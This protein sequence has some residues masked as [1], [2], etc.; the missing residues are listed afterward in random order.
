MRPSELLAILI[1]AGAVCSCRSTT[2]P[3]T[4]DGSNSTSIAGSGSGSGSGAD[5]GASS[6][7]WFSR[8]VTLADGTPAAHAIVVLT[9]LKTQGELAVTRTDDQG[10]FKVD[11]PGGDV[12][13]TAT[14]PGQMAYIESVDVSTDGPPIALGTDCVDAQGRIEIVDRAEEPITIR[15]DRLGRDVG[16]TFGASLEADGQF[17]V[18]LPPAAY[19]AGFPPEFAYRQ[20]V[21]AVPSSVKPSFRTAKTTSVE[22]VLD[23]LQGIE[24]ESVRSFAAGLP[25]TVRVLGIGESNHGTREFSDERT[26]LA[27]ELARKRDFNLVM[28][29]AGYGETLQLDRYIGGAKL[30]IADAVQ[31]LGYWTWDTKTFLDSLEQLRRYNA[32]TP[33]ARRIRIVGFDVQDTEGAI[34]YLTQR[35]GTSLSA[36]EIDRLG[37]LAVED[38]KNWKELDPVDRTAIRATL[39][40]IAVQQDDGG[41]FSRRNQAALSARSL[42]LRID[43]LETRNAWFESL[44]RDA[45]MARM[46]TDVLALDRH[47]R[48]SLW[49]HLAHLSRE[50]AVGIAT[51][52]HHLAAKLGASY[53]VYA[54][55]AHSGSARA[56]DLQQ[57]IGVVP[58]QL[59][60]MPTHSVEATLFRHAR[61]LSVTYWRFS[62]A[63]GDASRWLDGI[64]WL[65]EF[66]PVYP[67]DKDAFFLWDLRSIDGA[68]LFDR[69]TPTIST[70]TGER[71][72]K[73]ATP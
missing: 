22:R 60:A 48:A 72:A 40:R 58:H 43:C 70:P 65:A 6:P 59:P 12:A 18:C 26:H 32:S 35:S 49:A 31:K 39:E 9:D 20:N 68:V 28:I 25:S 56:W 8:V 51:A 62:R 16:D 10:R 61:G 50:R 33:L 71:V 11:M 69:V 3:R 34:A 23:S 1:V 57:K 42:L 21:L 54:L 2:P 13:L 24:P 30:D 53:Q 27:I 52:G 37:K 45:G 67:G 4:V 41:A 36:A 73:P 64:H 47:S 17:R 14:A 38:G 19:A 66:G 55:L 44:A 5:L 63:T 29:E 7:R 15:M 46:V